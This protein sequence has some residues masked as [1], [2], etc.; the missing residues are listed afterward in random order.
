MK[1]LKI[2]VFGAGRGA[3]L[4]HNF[5]A[6]DCDVVALCDFHSAVTM[7]SVGIPAHRSVPE[8]SVP[9]DIPDFRKEED[10]VKYE[11]DRLSPFYGS[12]GSLPTL[13]V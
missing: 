7:S 10:R 13:P 12:D 5:I 2:G 4:A 6:L 9:Y 11:N 8:G 1:R 3:Y